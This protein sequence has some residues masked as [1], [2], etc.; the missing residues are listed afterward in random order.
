MYTGES[1]AC[2]QIFDIL[3]Q[4][5]IPGTY[6]KNSKALK[7]DPCVTPVKVYK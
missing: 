7:S 1:S 6:M 4:Q 2:C 5:D 3:R